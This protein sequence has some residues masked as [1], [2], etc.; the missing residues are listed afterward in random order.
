MFILVLVRFGLLSGYLLGNRCLTICSLCILTICILV[1]SRFGFKGWIWD[2]IASGP[3]LFIL[4][5]LLASYSIYPFPV[6]KS[7]LTRFLALCSQESVAI[8]KSV[9]ETFSVLAYLRAFALLKFST[10]DFLW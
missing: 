3:D 8:L 4:F 10:K 2:R 5:K 6:E 9:S 1:I 7:H